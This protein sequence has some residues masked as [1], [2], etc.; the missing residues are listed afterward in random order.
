MCA[1]SMGKKVSGGF[2]GIVSSAVKFG[3]ITSQSGT[4]KTTKLFQDYNLSY[5]PE[6]KAEFLQVAFLHIPLFSDIYNRFKEQALP[7]GIFDKLLVREFDVSQQYSSR[8]AKY[9]IDG[10]KATK[11]LNSENEFNDIR[12]DEQQSADGED[13]TEAEVEAENDDRSRESESNTKAPDVP[14]K[15]EKE[16]SVKIQGPGINST[17]VI[18]EEEDLD[19]VEVMLKKVRKKLL[20]GQE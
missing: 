16:F 6:E 17:L 18:R 20:E 11:L 19:I 3:L 14:L 4:L 15:E 7:V 2:K 9:F 12:T 8:V 10:A 1:E 13:E 5:T